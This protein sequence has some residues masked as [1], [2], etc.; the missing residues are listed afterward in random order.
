MVNQLLLPN[1]KKSDQLSA[2]S[3]SHYLYPDGG[4]FGGEP[5]SRFESLH[6]DG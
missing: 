2:D 3:L 4:V 1:D 5:V 6:I